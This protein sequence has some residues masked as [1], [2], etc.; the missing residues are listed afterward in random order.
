MLFYLMAC[1][2]R[3]LCG[4]AF[5]HFFDIY[6]TLWAV[7]YECGRTCNIWIL[8]YY[9]NIHL[10]HHAHYQPTFVQMV[11]SD[12]FAI[13]HNVVGH[14]Q[15][16]L[17]R[18]RMLKYVVLGDINKTTAQKEFQFFNHLIFE[19]TSYNTFWASVIVSIAVS[20][21]VALIHYVSIQTFFTTHFSFAAFYCTWIVECGHATFRFVIT[22]ALSKARATVRTV[23]PRA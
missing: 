12:S 15:S 11:C 21:G 4:T 19:Y 6:T 5:F 14:F 10:L 23:S 17:L 9:V 8:Q 13:S 20:V 3:R 18:F 7:L 1:R 2:E 22:D 16:V